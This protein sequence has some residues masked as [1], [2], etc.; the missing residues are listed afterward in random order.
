MS[1]RRW[2][3][4]L[5][6]SWLALVPAAQEARGSFERGVEAYRRGDYAEA[7]S[8]WQAT[9][10]EDL[11]GRSRARVYFDLGN[12]RWRAGETLPAI[13]CY[14]AAVRLDPRHAE[15]WE[16]LE[17]ARAKAGLP[18]ADAGDLAATLKRLLTSLR[19]DERR[20][21]LFGALLLWALVLALETRLGGQGLRA[22][23]WAA[24]L[25]LLLAAVPWAHDRLAPR[26][27]RP[28]L[29]VASGGASLRSEPLDERAAVGEL[30]VLEQVERLDELPGWVRVQRHDGLRGWVK[31]EALLALA[32][33]RDG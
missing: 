11:D 13:A 33:G 31:A 28:M 8:A 16:N 2:L 1:V 21:L 26:S 3:V 19:A 5:A 10:A 32:L 17:L 4:L 15:A 9:L 22:A 24:T 29:V 18:P 7:A 12:A 14:T 27:V 20:A 6:L 25:V 23:L 30:A